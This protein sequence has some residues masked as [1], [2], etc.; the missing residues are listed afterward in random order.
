VGQYALTNVSV[1]AGGRAEFLTADQGPIVELVVTRLA[2]NG[3]GAVRTNYL[4]LTAVNVT[5]DLSGNAGFL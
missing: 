4:R 3:K 2:I 5:V 1:K